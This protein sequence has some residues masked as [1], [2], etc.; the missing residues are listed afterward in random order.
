MNSPNN[1]NLFSILIHEL[2]TERNVL[3]IGIILI[4]LL[5]IICSVIGLAIYK[6]THVEIGDFKIGRYLE[7]MKRLEDEFKK[8]K[9]QLNSS[10]EQA[11]ELKELEQNFFFKLFQL[12]EQIENFGEY[13]PILPRKDREP[14]YTLIQSVLQDI[15]FYEGP[16]NGNQQATH[17]ALKKF[18]TEYN[19]GVSENKKLS[20]LG[21]K[22]GYVTLEAIKRWYQDEIKLKTAILH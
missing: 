18:Q 20:R 8:C 16:L 1:K 11:K 22:L 2:I 6:G 3:V 7:D 19:E 21:K 17:N 14:V 4:L 9:D 12:E 15:D 13:I 10:S 5:L